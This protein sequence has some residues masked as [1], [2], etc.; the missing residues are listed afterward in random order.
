[1]LRDRSPIIPH[2]ILFP[3][4]RNGN[5]TRKESL[6]SEKLVARSW[7]GTPPLGQLDSREEDKAGTDVSQSCDFLRVDS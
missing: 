6:P 2:C 3:P 7:P 1:M 4:L 5:R